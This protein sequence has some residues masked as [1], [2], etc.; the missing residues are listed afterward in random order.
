MATLF[1][2][3]QYFADP[4]RGR[5]I[6]N[7]FIFIGRPDRDPTN[8]Q[9]RI[10]VSLICECGGSPVN[11]SQP[12]RTGPGGIPIYQGSPAQINVPAAEFSITVQDQN[13]VQIYYSPRATGF[14]QFSAENS[15]THLTRASAI[16]DSNIN[17]QFIKVGDFGEAQYVRSV[18]QAQYDTFPESGRFTDASNIQWVISIENEILIDYLTNNNNITQAFIDAIQIYKLRIGTK[19]K[20]PEGSKTLTAGR[21]V[22]STS[23]SDFRGLRV[24]GFGM[25]RSSLSLEGSGVGIT[26]D[27]TNLTGQFIIGSQFSEFSVVGVTSVT[28]TPTANVFRLRQCWFNVFDHIDASGVNG[29]VLFIG[30]PPDDPS[31]TDD[32]AV[33]FTTVS[34]CRFDTNWAG[35]ES[36]KDNNAPL[37]K[38]ENTRIV[39]NR[40]FGVVISSAYTTFDNASISFNGLTG[41]GSDRGGVIIPDGE[42][43]YRPPGFRLEKTELDTNYPSNVRINKGE[44]P[45]IQSC[46]TQI[47]GNVLNLHSS[48]TEFPERSIDIGNST[49]TDRIVWGARIDNLPIRSLNRLNLPASTNRHS[50]IHNGLLSRGCIVGSMTCSIERLTYGT[51]AYIIT[52]LN[53]SIPF[54][55]RYDPEKALNVPD[56][57]KLI[58]FNVP[59]PLFSRGFG[60]LSLVARIDTNE[61]VEFELPQQTNNVPNAL[62]TS[63]ILSITTTGLLATSAIAAVRATAGSEDCNNI[64]SGGSALSFSGS[65]TTPD[66]SS[67]T[68]GRLNIISNDGSVYF[69]NRGSLVNIHASWLS[70]PSYQTLA[71]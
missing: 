27:G 52:D 3:Y 6:F 38:I 30:S 9:D 16:A 43:I 26:I 31:F 4:T 28:A 7:G 63:N 42:S 68:S 1:N 59:N 23:T 22:Y 58:A 67:G 2:P 8:E 60:Q 70:N 19:I 20:L 69:V 65:N 13:R 40:E 34:H 51:D 46:S 44:N 61:I 47:N 71:I 15:V 35:I 10:Q 37:L 64:S 62:S 50:M 49:L 39:G 17:R 18:D 57:A 12:I 21:V 45:I 33:G 48:I 36:R 54:N 32:T 24:T 29:S 53:K 55:L 41:S 5:P 14:D 66:S 56:S 25:L 11:V